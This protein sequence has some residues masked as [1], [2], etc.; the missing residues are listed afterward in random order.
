LAVGAEKGFLYI[1]DE[2]D[3]VIEVIGLALKQAE[4]AG[5]LGDSILGSERS[6][7]LEVV[8]GGGAFV[9]GESTAL[10]QSIEGL[11]GEP[12]AKYIRSVERGLWGQPTVLNNVET[13]ANVPYIISRGGAEFAKVGTDNSKGTKVFSL[14][15][16][17]NRSGLV[18]VP[19]GITLRSLIYDI[20]GG[21]TDKRPFKAVQTGGPSGGCLPE[22]LLDLKVDFESL[23]EHD[24]MVG[25][26][27]MIVMDDR[28]CM[29]EVAHYYVDFLCGESCGKCTPC[30]EGLRHMRE[31]LAGICKGKGKLSDLDELEDLAFTL[32]EASLCALGK[33]A[34]NPV[35]STL[36]YFRDEYE[37]HINEHRCPAGICPALTTMRIDQEACTSC[38]LCLKACPVGAVYESAPAQGSEGGAKPDYHIEGD[39][40]TACGSCR[41][42]CRFD[43]IQ[44]IKREEACA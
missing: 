39:P 30:R 35:L 33:T 38:G 42:A 16:K 24:S 14:V 22:S 6:L 28:S 32:Q 41:E 8:R 12:R 25:S 11:V 40:C 43:A 23:L 13:L 31:I 26:G 36:R 20:G 34:A 15:G 10:M 17:V 3:L 2:Y 9:C 29:V 37:A 1:R 5:Y 21:I 7:H 18:E 27:G 19:M 44:A 4:E